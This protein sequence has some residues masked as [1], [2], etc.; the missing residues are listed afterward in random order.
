MSGQGGGGVAR[1]AQ[2]SWLACALLLAAHAASAEP[3][4]PEARAIFDALHVELEL[5]QIARQAAESVAAPARLLPP[6]DG[7]LL[8]SAVA[9]CFDSRAL[10]ARAL[11][12]FS[13]RLDA[14]H[15]KAALRW[16][17]R[18]ETRELLT[19]VDA[20]AS[21]PGPDAT[22][23]ATSLRREALLLR[24]ER[25]SG[26]AAR[27]ARHAALVFGAMLR[28]ANPLLPPVQRYSAEELAAL[29]S[30]LQQRFALAPLDASELRRRYAGIPSRGLEQAL[31]FL[32]SP[33]GAWLRRE[34]DAALERALVRAARA[35]AA[36][37]VGS[38]DPGVPPAPLQM[39]RA[40]Q[41]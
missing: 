17:A 5:E 28:A 37:L 24:F 10:A 18:P 3:A 8:R 27:S 36:Q 23:G 31:A 33:A 11:D 39:A 22:L 25:R 12:T 40:G 14:G 34:L 32:E 7:I 26:R 15:A 6:A 2:V 9:A 30:G 20:R 21:E 35:T 41:P 29:Q 19:R 38:L 1:H 16:L 4:E 13:A